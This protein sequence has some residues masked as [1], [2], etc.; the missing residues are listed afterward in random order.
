MLRVIVHAFERVCA[1]INVRL[2]GLH[3]RNP[4]ATDVG[5]Q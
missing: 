2:V 5:C 1:E 3:G 4:V